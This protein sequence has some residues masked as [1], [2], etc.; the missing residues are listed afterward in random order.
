MIYL[1]LSTSLVGVF[2]ICNLIE[3]IEKIVKHEEYLNNR[4]ACIFSFG[5]MVLLFTVIIFYSSIF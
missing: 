1:I 2:F 3:L 5:S 4:I